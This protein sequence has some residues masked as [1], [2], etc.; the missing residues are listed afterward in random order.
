MHGLRR[1]LF[2]HLLTCLRQNALGGE[3]IDG[4]KAQ[5]NTMQ[6][7][8]SLQI[9]S[10]VHVCGG[11]LISEDF[12]LTAAH[13]DVV[14]RVILGGHNLKMIDS[15]KVRDIEKKCKHPSYVRV[16]LGNDIMLLKLSSKVA[17]D[18]KV[19]IIK[20]PCAES[21]VKEKQICSVAGWGGTRSGGKSEDEL[22][23]VDVSIIKP[24]V[25]KD[26]W[27][28]PPDNVI[29]AGGYNTTKGFCQGDSGGP[30]VCNREA[31]GV[32]SFNKW[33]NKTQ[34]GNCD[35][36]DIPNVYTDISK[37]LPWINKILN[38]KDC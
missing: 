11:V 5:K 22:R 6:F 14:T 31:V 4:E 30:L 33:N 29:C 19:E 27:G 36:P 32:V 12:V 13:C 34:N 2:F 26:M 15:G 8:A 37:F 23:V 24:Q 25:C 38:A 35:Y 7:M 18:N 21:E 28:N 9:S 3:I 10:G 1:L 17:L 20:L 16:G